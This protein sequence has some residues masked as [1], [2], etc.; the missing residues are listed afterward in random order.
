MNLAKHLK[1]KIGT[2]GG[3]NKGSLLDWR[4]ACGCTII[5]EPA[6]WMIIKEHP[7]PGQ[8]MNKGL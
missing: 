7:R 3:N 2:I 4:S 5:A 1:E 8:S 6:K